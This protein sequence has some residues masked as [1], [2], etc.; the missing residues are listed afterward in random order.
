MHDETSPYQRWVR[1]VTHPNA[2][3][4]YPTGY[5]DEARKAAKQMVRI[6]NKALINI[7]IN[8]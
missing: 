1:A 5:Q 3:G 6:C 2:V 7:D 4:N 8:E